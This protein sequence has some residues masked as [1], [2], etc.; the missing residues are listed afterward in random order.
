MTCSVEEPPSFELKG[1]SG[2]SSRSVFGRSVM[3]VRMGRVE[4]VDKLESMDEGR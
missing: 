2:G 1:G 3:A 4:G